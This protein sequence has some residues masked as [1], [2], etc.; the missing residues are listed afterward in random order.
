ME[1]VFLAV[2][3]KAY[4]I[5]KEKGNIILKIIPKLAPIK[6]GVFPLVKKDFNQVKIAREIYSDL[7]ELWNVTYD[8][9]GSIGKR[10]ARNDEIGTP[11]CITIDENSIS[12][13]LVT[14][15]DRDTS[16]QI[17]IEIKNV[18]SILNELIL[19]K[20]TFKEISKK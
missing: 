10:Y 16:Q 15:R 2:L 9:S 1:R 11:F 4:S 5:D 13:S 6:V 3:S 18:K 20:K 12:R 19:G 14:I 7:K 8:D 17:S